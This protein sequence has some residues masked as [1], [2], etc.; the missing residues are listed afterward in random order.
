MRCLGTHPPRRVGLEW[1]DLGSDLLVRP[2]D[3]LRVEPLPKRAEPAV[4]VLAEARLPVGGTLGEVRVLAAAAPGRQR[5]LDT[6]GRLREG[7]A[8]LAVERYADGEE[9]EARVEVRERS[10]TCGRA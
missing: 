3:P 9:R 6:L 5:L 7:L 4:R 8:A 1:R 10:C 2:E